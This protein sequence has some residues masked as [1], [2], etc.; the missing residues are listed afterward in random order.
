[1]VKNP[2]KVAGA[3]HWD[4]YTNRQRY[5]RHVGFLKRWVRE[6]NT[7]DIGAGDGLI[8]HVL[9]IR[10]IDSDAYAIKLAAEKGVKVDYGNASRLPYKKEQFDSALMSDTLEYLRDI[11]KPLA[12]A[13]RVI[14]KYLYVSLPSAEKFTQVGHYHYWTPQDLVINVEH[15]GFRLVEGPKYKSDRQHYYFK[16]EKL[17]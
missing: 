16:F 7:I 10:G 8:T 17:A 9:G 13:R 4:W 2:Y 5:V 3:Y 14:K 6:P 12:E 11:K 1:M 15:Q